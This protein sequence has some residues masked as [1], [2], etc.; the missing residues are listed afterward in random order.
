MIALGLTNDASMPKKLLYSLKGKQEADEQ[1]K[2]IINIVDF[3]KV[4]KRDRFVDQTIDRVKEIILKKDAAERARRKARASP[5]PPPAM[6]PK[7]I[8]DVEAAA[9][10]DS[11]VGDRPLS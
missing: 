3:V 4:F 6:K 7:V 10:V 8:Y 5:S 9:E 11:I 2:P 1:V